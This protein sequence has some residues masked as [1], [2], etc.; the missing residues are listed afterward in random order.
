VS[1]TATQICALLDSNTIT[2][3]AGQQHNIVLCCVRLWTLE[4]E[5]C[6]P[7]ML[8]VI[9]LYNLQVLL[10][11]VACISY[12][13]YWLQTA[14]ICCCWEIRIFL[15]L[16]VSCRNLAQH[17]TYVANTFAHTKNTWMPPYTNILAVLNGS[18][19]LFVSPLKA[20]HMNAPIHS[21][22]RRRLY[23]LLSDGSIHVWQLLPSPGAAPIFLYAWTHLQK[24]QCMWDLCKR[25]AAFSTVYEYD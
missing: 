6:T 8:Q 20:K 17:D 9:A 10:S 1:W 13:K 2:C 5:C 4:L 14:F 3:S 21:L 7:C 24:E 16:S 12:I 25:M 22:T 23:V 15:N 11:F 19:Y 18:V